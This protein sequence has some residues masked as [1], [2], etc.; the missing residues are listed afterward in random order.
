MSRR[1]P[2]YT[3]L[4]LVVVM[5]ILAM[6]TAIAAPP[7][8]RMIRT[9][10]EATQV[11]DVLQQIARLPGTVRSGGNP[12]DL[13]ADDGIASIALPPGWTLQLETPLKVL[14]NGACSDAQGILNTGRQI[15]AFRIAA[16]FCRVQRVEG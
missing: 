12:L 11:D 16:P 6:A 10:Q 9:W 13:K 15:V 14:A 5:A 2:G 3:L 4:E 8:Y 1:P 7:S